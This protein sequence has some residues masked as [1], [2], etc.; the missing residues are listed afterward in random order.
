MDAYFANTQAGYNQVAAQYAEAFF[1]EL[2]NK[3]LDRELLDR[4]IGRVGKLG[5]I[6]D[7]GCGPGEIARYLKDHGGD[8]L[9]V[10]LSPEMIANARRLSPDIPFHVGN[11]LH[12]DFPDAAWGGIAA[13]YSIIHIPPAQVVDALRELKRVLK[14]GGWLLVTFHIG[15]EAVHLDEW[16]GKPVS[17]DFN[18]IQ[19]AAMDASMLEAGFSGIEIIVRDPYPEVEYQSRRG[20]LFARKPEAAE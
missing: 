20:Y 17:L 8:A 14:P 19:P 4:L 13:F 18:F 9:G 3:P 7:M 11:M 2:E 10:D 12:L 15:D 5:P 6:C 1:H 16:W